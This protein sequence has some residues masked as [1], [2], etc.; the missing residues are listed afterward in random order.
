[1]FGILKSCGVTAHLVEAYNWS[2]RKPA[3]RGA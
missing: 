2:F 3:V 1:V